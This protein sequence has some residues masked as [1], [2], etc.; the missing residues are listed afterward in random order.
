AA[1]ARLRELDPDGSRGLLVRILTVFQ[2]SLE[3]AVMQLRMASAEHRA[4]TVC[5]LAHK[6]KSSSAS[7]GASSLSAPCAAIEA[8]LRPQLDGE[9]AIDVTDSELDVHSDRL[10]AESEATLTLLQTMLRCGPC[11]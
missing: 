7:V 5:E 6:L 3:S 4:R 9:G 11:A 10:T 8:R 2:T 1:L